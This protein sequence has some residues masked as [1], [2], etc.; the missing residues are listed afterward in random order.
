[1]PLSSELYYNKK[2]H[3]RLTPL[4]YTTTGNKLLPQSSYYLGLSSIP[5]SLKNRVAVIRTLARGLTIPKEMQL[6]VVY[7]SHGWAK[8]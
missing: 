6:H 4:L 7:N 8:V 1:M 2:K 3:P 5:L